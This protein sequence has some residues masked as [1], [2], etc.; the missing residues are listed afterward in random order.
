MCRSGSGGGP[1]QKQIFFWQFL[2]TCEKIIDF[3]LNFV[4]IKVGKSKLDHWGFYS[5]LYLF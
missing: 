3:F 2:S 5:K 1:A 4:N